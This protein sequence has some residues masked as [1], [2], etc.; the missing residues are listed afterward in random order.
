[1]DCDVGRFMVVELDAW[2]LVYREVLGIK[3][4]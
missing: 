1:M 2:E 3:D 4:V